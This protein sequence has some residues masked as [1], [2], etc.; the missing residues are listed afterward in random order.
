MRLPERNPTAPGRSLRRRLALHGALVGTI[1]AVGVVTTLR[2]PIFLTSDNLL[3]ILRETSTY[4]IAASALALLIIAGGFDFSV[5]AAFSVG[6]VLAGEVMVHGVAWP[7]AFGVG[8]AAGAAVG[9]VNAV[10][11]IFSRV[12]P[13]IATLSVFFIAT[14]LVQATVKSL[15][16]PLP[17]G[18]QQAAQATL[19]GVPLLVWYAI[20]IGVLAW[21]VLEKTHFGYNLRAVGGNRN[22][23]H[24]T[25]INVRRLDL[26][27]YGLCGCAAALAGILYAA[28]TSAATADS[29]GYLLTL[30]V[31]TTV[32]VGGVSLRGGAG[33]IGGVALGA[34]L[35]G[36]L[37]N[38]LGV[39]GL[40]PLL[41]NVFV[42]AILA[43]AVALEGV[44]RRRRFVESPTAKSGSSSS[45]SRMELER[46]MSGRSRIEA[47]RT[48]AAITTERRRI[49]R[50]LHDGAQQ[51]LVLLGLKLSLA[52]KLAAT[53]PAAAALMH[54][55][56]RSDLQRALA[57]LR[58]LARGIY[59]QALERGGLTA[60]L[61]LAAERAAIP[62]VAEFDSVGRYGREVETG[63]YFCC[64]EALQNAAKH[65]GQRATAR[66]T[67]VATDD[68]LR[69][70]ILDTGQGF[71]PSPA[72][73]TGGMRNMTDRVASL[74]G[75]LT[76]DSA[77]GE[78]TAVRGEV[79]LPLVDD[80]RAR[81]DA[82]AAGSVVNT[83][84]PDPAAAQTSAV[85]K[86]PRPRSVRPR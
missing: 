70:E 52:E 67:L 42:G 82:E 3:E 45:V 39:A 18:F 10:L 40:D 80:S 15:I 30:Q 14:G 66:V 75:K 20:A 74:R 1:L 4:F 2:A 43:A 60:A 7:L 34:L 81:G 85:A 33:S 26:V 71:E 61:E 35:I 59:P 83:P 9:L 21:I 76:V 86:R 5:G 24:A 16:A 56:L 17:T 84:T 23:A 77:P 31:M 46:L 38:A 47:E 58:D 28:R 54:A 6:A 62:T 27:V 78:G 37:Q 32:L 73:A 65:A 11:V 29:G 13:M 41:S 64:L 19:L 79:P 63:V 69:F 22:A 12:P 68:R 53:D 36:E 57:E 49:E 55:E 44:G 51:Q 72:G 48:M 50:D 25:G 8:L